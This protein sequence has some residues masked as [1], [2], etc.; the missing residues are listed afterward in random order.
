MTFLENY[1][2]FI[3][4]LDGTL[5][6]G[7]QLIPGADQVLNFLKKKKTP[8]LLVTNKTTNTT[9]E[10]IDFLR[11]HGA[12]VSNADIIS[13]ASLITEHVSQNFPG[14]RF[15]A[16]GEQPF[17]NGLIDAGLE[18]SETPGKIDLVIITLDRFLTLNKL[19]LAAHA[20]ENGARFL[21]ANI[22][23]TCP[24]EGDEIWDAGSTIAAL[25]KRTHRKL[26]MH[27]GKPSPF[28]IDTILRRL[29]LPKEQLLLVGDRMETDIK[30]AHLAGITSAI[31]KT[32]VKNDLSDCNGTVPDYILNSVADLLSTMPV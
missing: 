9:A 5:Y 32:G 11:A 20:I 27:F 14:N 3:F 7:N 30:M 15:F 1:R 2:G 29:N 26:E 22:D 19:E 8:F 28:M 25:E 18:Y 6:R 21:A 31:V 17:I 23:D 4:D 24:V 16:L 13:A 12:D 10:Y